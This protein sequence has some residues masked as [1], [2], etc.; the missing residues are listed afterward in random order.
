M[1]DTKRDP[2]MIVENRQGA[3]HRRLTEEFGKFDKKGDVE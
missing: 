1:H 2:I 3:D